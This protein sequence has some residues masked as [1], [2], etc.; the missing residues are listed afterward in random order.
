MSFLAFLAIAFLTTTAIGAHLLQFPTAYYNS[1]TTVY[2]LPLEY[3]TMVWK[4]PYGRPFPPK[5]TPSLRL[6][7]ALLETSLLSP[8]VQNPRP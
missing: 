1:S 3:L 5:L 4:T 8:E 7:Y 6:P 2:S